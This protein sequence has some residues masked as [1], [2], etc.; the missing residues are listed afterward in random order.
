[1]KADFVDLFYNLTDGITSPPIFRK[2]AGISAI[3]GALERKVWLTSMGS[4]LYPNMYVILV[5]PPGVGKTEVTWR[6]RDLWVSLEDHFL[7]S[8]SISKASMIDELAAA[9]RRYIHGR[10]PNPVASFN[11]LLL[12]I[13][14]LGVLLPGYDNE[15]M[16]TLTDLWDC[17]HYSERKRTKNLEIQIPNP[18]LNLFAA[19]TPSYLKDLLPEG[20]WDQGLISRTMLVYSGD[21]QAASLFAVKPDMQEQEKLVKKRLKEIATLYG[22]FTVSPQAAEML[23]SFN[24]ENAVG[25]PSAPDHPKLV[26]YTIRRTVHLLKLSMVASVSHSTDLAITETDVE[27]ALDWMHEAEAQMP[28]I[29]KAMSASGTGN[30]MEEAWYYI[31]KTFSKEGKAVARHRVLQFLQERVPVHNVEPTLK[32]MEQSKMVEKK[33]TKAGAA[34]EPKGKQAPGTFT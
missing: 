32:L 29:F 20:A 14:E 3:A 5:A 7:G 2:W 26:S 30:V 9:A 21:R 19:C 16:N 33:L 11:S 1:M 18:Q 23:E 31:Y 34:Y 17:K 12:S 28:D 4:K 24:Q 6:I 8:T 22:E 13:N 25:S 27:R 10:P 15:F